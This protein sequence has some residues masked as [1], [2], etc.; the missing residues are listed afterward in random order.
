MKYAKKILHTLL[1]FLSFT[2]LCFAGK[3]SWYE[4]PI[5]YNKRYVPDVEQVIFESLAQ[6]NWEVKQTSPGKVTAWLNN[7]KGYELVLDI[8][9]DDSS[10][11]FEHISYKRIDCK[12]RCK[13]KQ[14]YYDKWRLYLR[15]NIALNIHKY[16]MSELLQNEKILAQW[17]N[18][19]TNGST[20]EK[21]KLARNIID[22]EYFEENTLNAIE[23]EIRNSNYKN[24]SSGDVVQQLAFYCKAL[25]YSKNEKY[26]P[27]LVEVRDNTSSEKLKRYIEVYFEHI[28]D[29]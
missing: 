15:K 2:P 1:L 28:N 9:H 20:Q 26:Q 14:K 18:T 22:I 17:M 16:A 6:R 24:P 11:S 25:A 29:P 10:I 27:L 13:A 23:Q 4:E 12:G 8:L 3:S 7:Y 19:I 5:T 21:T